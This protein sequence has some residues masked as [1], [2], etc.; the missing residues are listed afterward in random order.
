MHHHH[1]AK[2]TNHRA[3]V[4]CK[5]Q[6]CCTIFVFCCCCV[7][8]GDPHKFPG[9]SESDGGGYR[10]PA[11]D[12]NRQT[13]K[14]NLEACTVHFHKLLF[15][16]SSNFQVNP[17]NHGEHGLHWQDLD[18]GLHVKA[19]VSL[20]RTWDHQQKRWACYRPEHGL[21]FNEY[22]SLRIVNANMPWG[23]INEN[24]GPLTRTWACH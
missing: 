2:F 11:M 20:T 24:M 7:R 18:H 12:A 17:T 9:E 10:S 8:E 19:W 13:P 4:K 15:S 23:F 22:V 21:E 14:F 6:T 5:Y 1:L 3:T 16:I